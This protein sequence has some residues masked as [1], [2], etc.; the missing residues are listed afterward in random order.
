MTNKTDDPARWSERNGAKPRTI[1]KKNTIPVPIIQSPI[2]TT[3]E[4]KYLRGY[5]NRWDQ[6]YQATGEKRALGVIDSL[7]NALVEGG[8][9]P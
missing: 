8:G 3:A 4:E 2:I 5:R 7:N 6:Y 9:M 1:R